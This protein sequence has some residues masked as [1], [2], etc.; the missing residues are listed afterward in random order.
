MK[1]NIHVENDKKK[2]KVFFKVGQTEHGNFTLF[3]LSIKS[4]ELT[5][6]QPKGKNRIFLPA[7]ISKGKLWY[8]P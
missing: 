5:C 3:L 7:M 6:H 8:F 2:K 4:S 1:I